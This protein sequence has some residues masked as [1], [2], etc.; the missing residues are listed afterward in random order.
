MCTKQK[1]ILLSSPS[2]AGKP[3]R[4][5]ALQRKDK[6]RTTIAPDTNGFYYRKGLQQ[7]RGQTAMVEASSPS[8]HEAQP[9]PAKTEPGNY[10][11]S[12][13]PPFDQWRREAIPDYLQRLEEPHLTDSPLGLY[14]H[15]PFCRK[16]CN[17]C[18]F[19][20]Y[21]DKSNSDIDRY[22]EALVQELR[23]YA[24]KPKL[25]SRLPEFI[26]FGGGTPSYLSID[27]LHYLSERSQNILS[28]EKVKEIS[29]EGE[30]GTLNAKK[31]SAIKQLGV[32]R[33]S[34]G[35]ESFSDHILAAN[36][37]AHEGKHILSSY[38]KARELN[39]AQINI[40]LIAGL[41]EETD[42]SWDK[43]IEKTIELAPDSV[44]IYQLEIPLNTIL[45]KHIQSAQAQPVL[46]HS[47]DTKAEWV[48]RAFT[49]LKEAGYQQTS[50]YT[51]VKNPDCHQFIYRNALWHGADLLALGVASFGHISG[52]LYQNEKN[53]DHYISTVRAGLL[54]V[55]RSYELTQE[56]AMIREF[57]LQLKLGRVNFDDFAAKFSVDLRQQFKAQLEALGQQNLI[58]A[59][60]QGI[61]VTSD[62]LLTVDDWLKNFYL[63]HHR[64]TTAQATT[65]QSS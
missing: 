45:Y 36:N 14:F 22:T 38:E 30:P 1:V 64:S 8:K 48:R 15:I 56:E 40:D 16:R 20:I 50:A 7:I 49:A 41:Q 44:T 42:A 65:L 19:K 47:W 4:V 60:G 12:N 6:T 52:S 24:K 51:A 39:F 63:P 10:F 46:L 21:T 17:F 3:N 54:P 57:I 29:F 33:L 11:V 61:A 9:L 37:R 18:Y 35:V 32:T 2:Q 5:Y 62:G 13:Y 58:K 55:Q 23:Q 26:Y 59:D 31:L 28:W 34:L 25:K 53:F 27:Q 43:A